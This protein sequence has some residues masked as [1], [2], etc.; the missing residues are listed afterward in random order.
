MIQ[1]HSL[2]TQCGANETRTGSGFFAELERG[3]GARQ[4]QH[5]QKDA[6]VEQFGFVPQAARSVKP[7]HEYI[8]EWVVHVLKSVKLQ[9]GQVARPNQEHDQLTVCASAKMARGND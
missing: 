4:R 3:C 2:K 5:G 7:L 8:L 1:L 6:N 9:K